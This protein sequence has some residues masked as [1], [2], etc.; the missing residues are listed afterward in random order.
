M[1]KLLGELAICGFHIYSENIY[2]FI[3]DVNCY[4]VRTDIHNQI[5]IPYP[6][7]GVVQVQE[8]NMKIVII[9]VRFQIIKSPLTE[10]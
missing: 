1:A 8:Y 10:Y 2:S 5:N 6:M 4:Q 3:I 9:C 7:Q